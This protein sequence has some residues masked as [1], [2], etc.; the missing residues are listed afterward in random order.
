MKLPLYAEASILE[1]WIV[2]IKNHQILIHSLPEGNQYKK[3]EIAT[4]KDSIRPN[5]FPDISF[6]VKDILG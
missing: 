5:S 6:A 3:I 4:I 1:F 2:D